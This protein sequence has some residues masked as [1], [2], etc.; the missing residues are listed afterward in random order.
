MVWP[1]L[2]FLCFLPLPCPGHLPSFFLGTF[3]SQTLFLLSL[4]PGRFYFQAFV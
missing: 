3:Q 1:R 4:W 2:L